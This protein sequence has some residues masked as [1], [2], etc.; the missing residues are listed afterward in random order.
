M[1]Q[2]EFA[3]KIVCMNTTSRVNLHRIRDAWKEGAPCYTAPVT[4]D[5][6]VC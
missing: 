5:H 6:L 3:W 1:L 4:P 2:V